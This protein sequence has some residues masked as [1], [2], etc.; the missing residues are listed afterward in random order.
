MRYASSILLLIAALA[1]APSL[2]ADGAAPPATQALARA[3]AVAL[4]E[5]PAPP[6]A[7]LRFFNRDIVT[8]RA[9]YFGSQPAERAATAFQRIRETIAKGGPGVVNANVQDVFNE[10]GVQIMSPHYRFDPA[11]PGVVPKARWFEPPA[12]RAGDPLR[13]RLGAPDR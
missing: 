5:Q 1:P 4:T 10:Y 12:A 6:P 9:A 13:D 11:E 7:A 2:A 3:S 8:F